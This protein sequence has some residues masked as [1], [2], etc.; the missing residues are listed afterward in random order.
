MQV[1][2]GSATLEIENTIPEA[3]KS[4]ISGIHLIVASPEGMGKTLEFRGIASTPTDKNI[5]VVNN[6]DSLTSIKDK[7]ISAACDGRYSILW[8]SHYFTLN[9]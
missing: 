3:I 4:R 8:S 6:F 7:V 9:C 5:F 1:T 2:D